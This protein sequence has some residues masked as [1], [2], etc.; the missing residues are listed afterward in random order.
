MCNNEQNTPSNNL[1]KKTSNVPGLVGDT[2]GE[3]A[4]TAIGDDVFIAGIS[5]NISNQIKQI[6]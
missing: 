3:R 1:K 4:G 2:I 5:K 6:R